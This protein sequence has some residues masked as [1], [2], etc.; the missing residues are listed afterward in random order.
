MRASRYTCS[1]VSLSTFYVSPDSFTN[2]LFPPSWDVFAEGV[3]HI[4]KAESPFSL[5]CEVRFSFTK[6][7]EFLF[8]AT[9]G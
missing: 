4:I 5:P 2:L 3:P 1:S 9:A 7:T 6:T 8:T